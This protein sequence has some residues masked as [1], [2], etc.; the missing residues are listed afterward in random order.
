MLDLN[1]FKTN[2]LVSGKYYNIIE[3][4]KRYYKDDGEEISKASM[5]KVLGD[6]VDQIFKRRDNAV[7]RHMLRSLSSN[8]NIG[9]LTED[10]ADGYEV[11]FSIRKYPILIKAIK[12]KKL[13]GDMFYVCSDQ[14]YKDSN[15]KIAYEYDNTFSALDILYNFSNAQAF[16]I[17]DIP[18]DKIIE[19]QKE[20][21]RTNRIRRV[22]TRQV[23]GFGNKRKEVAWGQKLDT[24]NK[25]KEVAWGQK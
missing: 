3:I 25:R 1:K 24:E 13:N 19:A 4:H 16:S 21:D 22:D 9:T 8:E 6:E 2:C 17:E 10:I 15:D 20:I 14:N 18:M 11:R 5:S 12:I 23:L 7:A